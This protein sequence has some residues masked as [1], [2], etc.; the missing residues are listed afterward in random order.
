[1]N[2]CPR[3]VEEEI[4]AHP[5]VQDAAVV[6][7][8]H[9]FWGEEVVAFIVMKQS[10]LFDQT[11]MHAYCRENLPDDAVPASF[12]VLDSFPRSSTGKIQKNELREFL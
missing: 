9:P 1:M 3:A 10:K 7:R 4:Y 2:V 6:G 11:A 12:I 5:D 8:P